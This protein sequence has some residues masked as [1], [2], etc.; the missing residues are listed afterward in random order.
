VK[1][2]RFGEIGHNAAQDHYGPDDRLK[3]KLELGTRE[4]KACGSCAEC[5]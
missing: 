5:D 3:M 4:Q 1:K 2:V